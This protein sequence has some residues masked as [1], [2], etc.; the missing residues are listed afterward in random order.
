MNKNTQLVISTLFHP[1]FVNIVSL[2]LLFTLFPSLAAISYK[3]KSTIIS[4]IISLTVIIP[5]V[6]VGFLKIT[7]QISS[8]Q[9][10]DKKDRKWPFAVT[11]LGYIFSF[12]LLQKVGVSML[13]LKFLLAGSGTV[14]CIAIVNNFWKISVHMASIGGLL[15]LLVIVNLN[16][17]LDLRLAVA[18]VV[19]ISGIV[20]SARL[21][22]KA[23]NMAQIL[24]GFALGFVWIY[25]VL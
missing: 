4:V 25:I 20:A 8:M 22:A 3:S 17:Y 13:L 21:F 19:L 12:Y 24:A 16:N 11:A 14:V 5:L 10:E 1:I 18:G 2:L 6:L 15:G 23:H 7:N 9:M